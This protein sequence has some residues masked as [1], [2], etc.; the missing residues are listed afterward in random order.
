VGA[1]ADVDA[2]AVALRQGRPVVLHGDRG[3][4]AG[5]HHLLL[6]AELAT[7]HEVAFMV[8]HTSGFLRAVLTQ[9]DADRLELPLMYSAPHR[10][11]YAVAVDASD[12]VTTGISA[13]DRATTLRTLADPAT[14]AGRLRRPGHVIPVRAS[15]LGLIGRPGYAEAVVDL[16]RMA[17]LRPTGALSELVGEDGTPMTAAQRDEF[18]RTHQL[19]VVSVASV[20]EHRLSHETFVKRTNESHLDVTGTALRVVSFRSELGGHTHLAL[21]VGRIDAGTAPP[22]HV[23]RTGGNPRIRTTAAI[24]LYLD[25]A[26]GSAGPYAA[27]LAP[28]ALESILVDQILTDLGVRPAIGSVA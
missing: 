24:V 6:A 10:T 16:M 4:L 3:E 21:C 7:P 19:P 25:P 12:N 8:R 9:A 1:V 13:T 2:V 15:D 27:T 22:V 14:D 5:D 26:E 28:G 11:P 23:V 17:R 18:C 20:L